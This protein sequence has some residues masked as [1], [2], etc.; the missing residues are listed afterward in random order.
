MAKV[1]REALEK[2]KSLAT[3]TDSENLNITHFEWWVVTWYDLSYQVSQIIAWV[4]NGKHLQ[5]E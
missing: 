2:Y 4:T 5:P 1:R 3:K